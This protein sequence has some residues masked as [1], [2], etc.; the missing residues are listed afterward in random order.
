MEEEY[1]IEITNNFDEFK[2]NK[3]RLYSPNNRLVGDIY[4]ELQL[5]DVLLQIK[6]NNL[7]GYYIIINDEERLEIAN[8]GRIKGSIDTLYCDMLKE[9]MGLKN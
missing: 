2:G 8:T 3:L 4:T 7:S 9:L 6:R 1:S 5:M